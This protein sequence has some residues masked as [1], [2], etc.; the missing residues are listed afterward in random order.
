MIWLIGAGPMAIEYAKVLDALHVEFTVIGRG[1]T[2]SQSFTEK[3]G[4]PVIIGG[5]SQFLERNPHPANAAIVSV[6]IEHLTP[7]T[8]LLLDYGICNILLEKPGG[9]NSIE[10]TALA[11]KTQQKNATVLLAY[12]RRFYSSVIEAQKI[13]EKD[14]GVQSFNFEFTEWS[15]LIA[16]L[17]HK[18]SMTLS[19]W[20]L[21]SST[22]VADLAFFLGG[23][24]TKIHSMTAGAL[25]WHPAASRFSGCGITDRN[26]LFSYHANWAAPG[27]WGVEFLTANSRLIFRPMEKLQIQKIGSVEIS[28]V[29]IDNKL[30]ISFKPGLYLQTKSFL[31][32]ECACFCDISKQSQSM[33]LYNTIAGYQ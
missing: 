17:P 27:R 16:N 30:D 24:P 26:A 28:D 8:N 29:S 3:T 20:F 19:N 18:N 23:I 33:E 1:L 12:N 13:I 25:D 5:L 15:H 10:I 4:K 11:R 7:A 6:G 31:A 9:V 32:N 22:H 21:A 2:S 14:G